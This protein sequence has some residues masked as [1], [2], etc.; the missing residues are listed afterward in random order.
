MTPAERFLNMWDEEDG[1]MG[2][3][4]LGYDMLGRAIVA[5]RGAGRS[6][7]PRGGMMRPLPGRPGRPQGYPGGYAAPMP[8]GVPLTQPPQWRQPQL[9]PGV[10]SPF[11]GLVPLQLAPDLNSGTLTSA[12]TSIVFSA[13]PQKPFRGQRMVAI[14]SK[15]A[16]AAASQPRISG[17][18]FVGTDLQAAS[19]GDTPLEAYAP[20][21]F[22]VEMVL[23]PAGPG[24]NIRV[25][26]VAAPAV[27]VGET[28]TC[29]I[30]I[31]GR[32]IA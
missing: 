14:V 6:I 2:A 19:F 27:P 17:G 26:V 22:G 30:V 3:E 29:S 9:A 7:T 21:A 25:P 5:P 11:E 18:I 8:M 28:I 31:F 12:F 13:Q 23:T 32:Y 1:S 24:I 20:T 4:V 15:S 10:M 16:G